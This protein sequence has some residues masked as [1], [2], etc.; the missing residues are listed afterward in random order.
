MGLADLHLG[1][2]RGGV[3]RADHARCTRARRHEDRR[4]GRADGRRAAPPRHRARSHPREVPVDLP[5]PALRRR[6]ALRPLRTQHSGL[7]TYNP[8]VARDLRSSVF[9]ALLWIAAFAFATGIFFSITL[10]LGGLPPTAPVAVGLVTVERYSKLK[11][12]IEAALFFLTVPPLTVW[13]RWIGV[14]LLAR[15]QRR[16][17]TRRDMPVA[18]LFTLPFL[19]SPLFYLT[20]GKAGWILVL[21]VALAYA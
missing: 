19:L 3:L 17:V 8:R 1:Q 20:T 5:R 11:D 4:G 7:R 12:Y 14:R 9:G 13:L 21:P 15:E 16:F 6:H 2:R 18:L 10:L